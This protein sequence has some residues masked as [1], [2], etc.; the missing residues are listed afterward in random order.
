MNFRR[1]QSSICDL[2]R[3]ITNYEVFLSKVL[4]GKV[5]KPKFS[6]CKSVQTVRK[7]SVRERS[8]MPLITG[9]SVKVP[10]PPKI[11]SDPLKVNSRASSTAEHVMC[12]EVFE[13]NSATV[14]VTVKTKNANVGKSRKRPR[15][16][17][18]L[19]VPETDRLVTEGE[20]QK[21]SNVL[22]EPPDSSKLNRNTQ[23]ERQS[24]AHSKQRS[25]SW[26]HI[27]KN[28]NT[29]C[30]VH[31]TKPKDGDVLDRKEVYANPRRSVRS[32]KRSNK[33]LVPE[34]P[35][36]SSIS[37]A[38][39]NDQ[40]TLHCMDRSIQCSLPEIKLLDDKQKEVPPS[41]LPSK[42]NSNGAG[43]D[44][45]SMFSPVRT[46]NF[47]VKELRGKLQNSGKCT[48]SLHTVVLTLCIFHVHG[49]CI[50]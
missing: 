35:L 33:Y 7:S 26:A 11:R 43:D 23:H 44:N 3:D 48:I 46:L 17:T 45:F 49:C 28:K 16:N 10:V 32:S 6:A 38:S 14:E 4:K 29:A 36:S 30:I 42:Y 39:S 41:K 2:E 18:L 8:V 25:L 19:S 22:L 15:S 9:P 20:I 1:V 34:I 37:D 40:E 27:L 47:L 5:D 13:N 50:K 24:C 31:N 21:Q 12:K